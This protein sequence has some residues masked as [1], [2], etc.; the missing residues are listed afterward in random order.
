MSILDHL[1]KS[2]VAVDDGDFMKSAVF[3]C[4]LY[5]MGY[6]P[7]DWMD[8]APEDRE[9]ILNYLENKKNEILPISK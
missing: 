7:K 9:F 3:E 6:D 5:R 2:A 8:D 1:P 4:A